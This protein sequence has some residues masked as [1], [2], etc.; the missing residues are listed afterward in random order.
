[1]GKTA[2]GIGRSRENKDSDNQP[3]DD[4]R[5][6]VTSL[7]RGTTRGGP[8]QKEFSENIS[9]RKKKVAEKVYLEGVSMSR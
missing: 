6:Q 1:M 7:T 4:Q 2:L 8:H 3:V 9:G 5:E